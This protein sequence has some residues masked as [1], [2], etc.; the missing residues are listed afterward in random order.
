MRRARGA[1]A[2]DFSDSSHDAVLDALADPRLHAA[3]AATT[4]HLG[5][6]LWEQP[7]RI[8]GALNDT[9]GADA[10]R[11]RGAVDLLALVADDGAATLN[12]GADPA[13]RVTA[14]T[15]QGI[16]PAAATAAVSLWQQ[17]LNPNQ[18]QPA[19]SPSPPDP[20]PNPAPLQPPAP[21]AA[22]P[23]ATSTS[24]SLPP[25]TALV[26]PPAPPS[27]PQPTSSGPGKRTW[28]IAL[29]A[30]AFAIVATVIAVIAL[31]GDDKTTVRS[32]GTDKQQPTS[33][34]PQRSSTTT[35]PTVVTSE[36]APTG[37]PLENPGD[38]SAA[39]TPSE[40]LVHQRFGSAITGDCSTTQATYTLVICHVKDD[41]GAYMVDF[42][43]WDDA[44]SAEF[45]MDNPPD[46]VSNLTRTEWSKADGS[47]GGTM[48]SY[49][50]D[51][52]GHCTVWSY[53]GTQ[54]KVSV[55]S[56]QGIDG[57]VAEW[58]QQSIA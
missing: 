12:P 40:A 44:E 22:P 55:C 46:R 10:R 42:T 23:A 53:A 49:R 58:M 11:F 21:A 33:T 15:S 25:P 18:P 54:F 16:D 30:A 13:A 2:V 52:L 26:P 28:L 8:R 24:S 36:D 7:A 39:G 14:L 51:S 1:G 56:G 3:L 48:L 6:S 27:T 38:P 50:D 31:S 17:V 45:A 32:T 35:P 37:P 5:A 47:R 4:S 41:F 20:T 19:L 43:A 34:S 57:A 29:G 9:L